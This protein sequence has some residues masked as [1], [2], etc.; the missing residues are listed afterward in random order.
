[1]EVAHSRVI[2]LVKP[3]VPE[4]P[5]VAQS[6]H[7][8]QRKRLFIPKEDWERRSQRRESL[9]PSMCFIEENYLPRYLCG[10][11]KRHHT[12]LFPPN[13]MITIQQTEWQYF[14]SSYFGSH[15]N[16]IVV[17]CLEH[18]MLILN[19]L[20]FGCL[21]RQE[22][23]SLLF[24]L[25][26][27]GTSRP[28]HYHVLYDENK[29]TADALQTLT[30]NLCYMYARCTRSV[31]IVPPAYYAHLAA[32]R[33]RYY[34]EGETS[35]SESTSGGRATRERNVEVRPLPLIK[36]NVKEVMFYC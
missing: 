1:M 5:P 17:R 19:L 27:Q 34:I 9:F 11:A 16:Y 25:Y 23:P 32:F 18:S 10:S 14:T 2:T 20:L 35:E 15:F 28:A 21:S 31:S 4:K 24:A 13:I 7:L 33:A 8:H 3:R 12:R 22:K 29:F 36:D 6:S 26:E 30:N